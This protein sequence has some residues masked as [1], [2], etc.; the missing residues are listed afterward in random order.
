MKLRNHLHH[1]IHGRGQSNRSFD[2]LHSSIFS[3]RLAEG[4]YYTF[5]SF[6]K[7]SGLTNWDKTKQIYTL[8]GLQQSGSLLLAI[9]GREDCHNVSHYS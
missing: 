7:R 1:K 8:K 6:T 3:I 2:E 4:Y 5:Q 9:E